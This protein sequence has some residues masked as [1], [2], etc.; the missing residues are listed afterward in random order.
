MSPWRERRAWLYAVFH[1]LIWCW[2]R[3]FYGY[4]AR[5]V[6]HVPASGGAY[7]AANHVSYLDPVWI[8][9]GVVH[10][11]VTIMSTTVVGRIPVLGLLVRSVNALTIL[12]R[13]GFNKDAM[14]AFIDVVRGGGRLLLVFPEGTR[15]A[16]GMLAPARRGISLLARATGAPVVP[17]LITG[18]H[19]IWPKGRL[20]FRPWG[21]IS[22][23]F[24]PPLTFAEVVPLAGEEAD[25]AFGRILMERIAA[26]ADNTEPP[27]PFGSGLRAICGWPR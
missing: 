15:S 3:L 4:R 2:A 16:D 11:Q 22:V 10:R 18:A 19:G 27:V 6:R 14:E 25:D 9:A 20:W 26:C 17:A 24:G 13:T 12:N 7:I 21:R 23:T 5:G 1:P 8:G